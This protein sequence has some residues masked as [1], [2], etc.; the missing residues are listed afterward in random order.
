MLFTVN[1]RPLLSTIGPFLTNQILLLATCHDH[2][3][4][5]K[6]TYLFGEYEITKKQ[7]A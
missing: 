2:L 7:N 6:L 1:G 5:H 3:V 4:N